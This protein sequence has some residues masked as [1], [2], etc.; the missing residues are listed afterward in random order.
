MFWT[1]TFPSLLY[2]GHLEIIAEFYETEEVRQRR[3]E[4]RKQLRE[5]ARVRRKN[6]GVS[7]VYQ[8]NHINP[9]GNNTSVRRSTNKSRLIPPNLS[10]L[11]S[12]TL[13]LTIPGLLHV[14]TLFCST[15][16]YLQVSIKTPPLSSLRI[17]PIEIAIGHGL[18]KIEFSSY[19][20]H[21]CI[22]GLLEASESDIS[23]QTT[24]RYRRQSQRPSISVATQVSE[25]E[26]SS[27]LI[28]SRD[29][30][31]AEIKALV[32]NTLRESSMEVAAEAEEARAKME[33]LAAE[34]LAAINGNSFLSGKNLINIFHEALTAISFIIC[35]NQHICQGRF[36]Y[37]SYFNKEILAFE[38]NVLNRYLKIQMSYKL[39][40][41][42]FSC[43]YEILKKL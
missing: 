1:C 5:R 43:A 24:P 25:G 15:K 33:S 4:F 21:I 6:F 34:R 8:T 22:S 35:Q 38:H 20:F 3:E 32:A 41:S 28:T 7:S 19:Q 30:V 13:F 18:K 31:T 36:E 42:V 10:N 12:Q 37:S 26:R 40:A 11:S 2:Q 29:P 23:F 16:S 17:A 27:Q 39:K 9:K 14:N